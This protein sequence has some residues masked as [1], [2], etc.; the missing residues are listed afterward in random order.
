M[1]RTVIKSWCP[2]TQIK[3]LICQRQCMFHIALLERSRKHNHHLELLSTK[4]KKQKLKITLCTG[5]E[6]KLE[7]LSSLSH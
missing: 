7:L 2:L 1:Q 6:A 3:Q 5:T 4:V